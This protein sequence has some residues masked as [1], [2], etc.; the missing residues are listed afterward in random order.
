MK[1]RTVAVA[2]ALV[3]AITGSAFAQAP[4]K[5][6]GQKRDRAGRGVQL[7]NMPVESLDRLV[8]LTAD[9]KTKITAIHDK[10]E[11]DAKALPKDPSSREKRR[12]LNR[13]A[14]QQVMAILTDAQKEKLQGAMKELGPI[15]GAGIP[16]PL[17]QE[18]KL[19]DDQ[20]KKIGDIVAE[21]RK[22]AASGPGDRKAMREQVQAKIAGI[23]TTE[24]KA[25][26]T[27]YMAE[28]GKGR[29]KKK[30]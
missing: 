15:A 27:K 3:F 20:K 13:S 1:L 23:L 28:H 10:F 6:K 25:V 4:A 18:L 26:V 19:T 5:Q 14:T 22:N 11:A 17:L 7:A 30:A 29:K 2:A 16:I 9:Q 21:A 8:T 24:Q 12:D